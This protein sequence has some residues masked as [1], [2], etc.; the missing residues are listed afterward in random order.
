MTTQMMNQEHQK[1][2][3]AENGHGEMT[4]DVT[5]YVP[6]VD[7]ME[8]DDEIVLFADVDRCPPGGPPSVEGTAPQK[9]IR[10]D[11]RGV[12]VA[13]AIESVVT[14]LGSKHGG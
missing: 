2:E 12:E 9:V 5:T 14:D 1:Q 13:H 8:H 4:R 3:Q 6:R 7:I 10:V 11:Q